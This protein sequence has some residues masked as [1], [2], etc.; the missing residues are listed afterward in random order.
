MSPAHA[1][2]R[3][4]S[5]LPRDK[6]STCPDFATAIAGWILRIFQARRTSKF[7]RIG[8]DSV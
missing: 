8:F 2:V 1:A 7:S 4:I 6:H 3:D 5:H